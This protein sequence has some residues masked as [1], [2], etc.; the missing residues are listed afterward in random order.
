M[1]LP[2]RRTNASFFFLPDICVFVF[3]GYLGP[4]G[5]HISGETKHTHNSLTVR[6][7]HIKHVC[8][9]SG[10][11]KWRGHLNLCA[12]NEQKLRLRIVIT[13]F[14]CRFD[15]GRSVRLH[16][17]PTQSVFRMFARNFVPTCFGA[18]GSGMVRKKMG[19]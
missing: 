7:G 4:T 6:Q 18:P 16:V 15:F 17:G 2:N 12:V 13:W 3:F 14:Q 11:Q 10:S 5:S 8:K 9:I 1:P 19:N